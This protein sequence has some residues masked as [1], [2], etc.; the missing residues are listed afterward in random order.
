[1]VARLM[2]HP[3]AIIEFSTSPPMKR[4]GGPGVRAGLDRPGPV[5]EVEAGRLAEDLPCD[6]Q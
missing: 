6:V 2:R 4:A 1:M 3:S 5:V